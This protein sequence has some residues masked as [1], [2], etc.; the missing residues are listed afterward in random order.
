MT[1]ALCPICKTRPPVQA[2]RPFCSKRCA[3]IDLQ[4]WFTGAY[5]IP[6]VEDDDEPPG[7]E[8]DEG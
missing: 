1:R 2:F 5:A 7:P 3:D 8:S 6:A 4:R